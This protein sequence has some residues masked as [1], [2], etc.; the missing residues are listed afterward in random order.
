MGYRDEVCSR[1]EAGLI[2]DFF[3]GDTVSVHELLEVQV[4][5]GF[6]VGQIEVCN[7]LIGQD[8]VDLF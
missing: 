1:I 6:L 4:I 2:V 8:L 7:I 3:V 5:D